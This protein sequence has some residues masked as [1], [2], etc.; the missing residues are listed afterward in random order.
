MRSFSCSGVKTSRGSGGSQ[1]SV[2]YGS[3]TVIMPPGMSIWP[4]MHHRLH[5]AWEAVTHCRF[6][7]MARPHCTAVGFSDMYFAA[8]MM[9]SLS[10]QVTSEA[11]SRL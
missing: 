11:Q 1:T 6:M 9:S 8:A 3:C 2:L 10:S 7:S 5:S 4:V